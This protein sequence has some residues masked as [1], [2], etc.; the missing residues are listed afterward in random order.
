VSAFRVVIAG[1]PN[2]ASPRSSTDS[3]GAARRHNLPGTLSDVL[4]V[5]APLPDGRT[6]DSDTRLRPGGEGR[7]PPRRDKALEAIRRADLVL[8]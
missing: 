1:R 7:F 3:A 6:I 2:V 5:E 8:W 4:E